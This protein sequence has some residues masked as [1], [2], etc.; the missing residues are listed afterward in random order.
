MHWS[1]FFVQPL[2][3]YGTVTYSAQIVFV[4][5]VLVNVVRS[6]NIHIMGVLYYK[7]IYL[8]PWAQKFY[9]DEPSCQIIWNTLVTS[10]ILFN[11]Y[12]A[13]CVCVARWLQKGQAF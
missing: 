5:N 8:L 1:T 6:I 9:T 10:K 12:W 2:S 13:R 7:V 3:L 11:T 4:V